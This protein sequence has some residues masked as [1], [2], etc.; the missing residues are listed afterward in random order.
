MKC[1]QNYLCWQHSSREISTWM[2][3][4]LLVSQSI[5][6]RKSIVN[7]KSYR[8]TWI[9][10]YHLFMLCRY[11]FSCHYD[12][13]ESEPWG[14]GSKRSYSRFESRS[15]S[16]FRSPRP[17]LQNS[18]SSLARDSI[19]SSVNSSPLLSPIISTP[20]SNFSWLWKAIVLYGREAW[21]PSRI[22][23]FNFT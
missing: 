1:G 21:T 9:W 18:F 15:K 8:L 22:D 17:T 16:R 6:V 11:I 23:P 7:F 20:S 5:S 13:Y 10:K 3:P 4:T 14:E 2:L 19:T 12:I